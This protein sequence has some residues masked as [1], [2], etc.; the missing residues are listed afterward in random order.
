MLTRGVCLALGLLATRV[1]ADE[2]EWRAATPRAIA[3]TPPVASGPSSFVSL[4]RPVPM[5][6]GSASASIKPA[7][8][9][10]VTLDTPRPVF[11]AKGSDAAQPMPAGPA[12]TG[13]ELLGPPRPLITGT[14]NSPVAMDSDIVSRWV[15]ESPSIVSGAGAMTM[16][17]DGCACGPVGCDP[18]GSICC[19]PCAPACGDG[20]CLTNGCCAD[21]G[22]FWFSGE[23]LLWAFKRDTLPP[24]VTGNSMGLPAALGTP[25]TTVL[26]GG[27]GT[28]NK[29]IS[30]G[31][32]TVGFW[33][34]HCPD[35]GFEGSYFMLGQLNKTFSLGSNGSLSL[36]RP[37]N[38]VNSTLDATGALVPPGENV[39]QVALAPGTSG[40]VMVATSS[41]LWGAEANARYKW[42]CGECWHVDFLSGFRYVDLDE[43]VDITENLATAGPGGNTGVLVS[44]RFGTRDQFYGGQIGLDTELKWGHWFLGGMFKLAMGD[45]YESVRIGGN[46]TFI[47]PAPAMP[48]SQNGG[49]LALASNIGTYSRNRFAV[50]PEVGLKFGVQV[51]EHVRLFAGYNFLYLSD[52]VRPGDQIDRRVNTNQ[53]PNVFQGTTLVQPALPSVLFKPTDFWAQG[54]NAGLEF[55]Y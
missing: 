49:V 31:R 1:Q 12:L 48:V 51:T 25:G 10:I 43:K 26:F 21:R 13:D 39:E 17:G 2:I 11:R 45:M 27:G 37:L 32:A 46:T 14:T 52:V 7:S 22:H 53:F 28:D 6:N 47:P 23:Y 41:R 54:L 36:G 44:D 55:R 18:C 20:C 38:V 40:N 42:L 9:E 19:D 30:G 34:C 15:G 16:S 24:L 4:E 50:V 29:D 33:C 5:G 35:L 3:Q 8:F